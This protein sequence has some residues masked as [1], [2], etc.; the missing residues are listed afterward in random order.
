MLKLTA[1]YGCVKNIDKDTATPSSIALAGNGSEGFQLILV[2]PDTKT[3]K[4]YLKIQTPDG[5]TATVFRMCTVPTGDTRTVDP[6]IPYSWEDKLSIS[7]GE[8]VRFY[9]RVQ[10]NVC[11]IRGEMHCSVVSE[12][13]ATAA[14]TMPVTVWNFMLPETPA[15]RVVMGIE[16]ECIAKIHGVPEFG[17][18][19]DALYLQY[20]EVAM[21]AGISPYRIPCPLLDANGNW[22]PAAE[23]YLDNPRMTSFVIPVTSLSD[24]TY[25]GDSYK[26][27][28][29]FNEEGLKTVYA[30]LLAHP[31]WFRKAYFYPVDEPSDLE[32]VGRLQRAAARLHELCPGIGIVT[33]FWRETLYENGQDAI[34]A[35]T[36]STDIWCPQS[37]FFDVDDH[38]YGTPELKERHFPHFADRM[39]ERKAAGDRIWWYTCWGPRE[40]YCNML[41][42]QEGILHRIM[43]WL[44]YRNRVEGFLYW[45][46]DYW[47]EVEDP[48]ENMTTVPFLSTTVYGDGS[49]VYNGNKIDKFG[50]VPSLRMEI[51]RTAIDDYTLLALAQKK[52][53]D[54]WINQKIDEIA[55]GM[56]EFS[57]DP[58]LLAKVRTEI[59]DALSKE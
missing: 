59:G 32:E 51:I 17:P 29:G 14:L 38:I 36:G 15:C 48:W 44:Q 2:N 1:A 12:S 25:T 27:R 41:I 7:A 16:R 28:E 43:F 40:P 20:Y 33:P 39:L 9:V 49:L 11:G 8:T 50:A 3:E 31:E 26:I 54:D 22:N 37:H 45:C 46:I 4:A 13:R 52:F 42:D 5:I 24:E 21:D 19:N 47:M 10:A 34:E 18:E 35:L 6:L 58:V 30:K 56:K 53:G 55:P 57:R 23:K